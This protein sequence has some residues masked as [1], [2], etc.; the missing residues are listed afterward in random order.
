MERAMIQTVRSRVGRRLLLLT[1]AF[2]VAGSFGVAAA[3]H[4]CGSVNVDV[5]DA[6]VAGGSDSNRCGS[7]WTTCGTLTLTV[8]NEPVTKVRRY[9]SERQRDGEFGPA[10]ETNDCAKTFG[11]CAWEGSPKVVRS[12]DSTTITQTL[13][14]WTKKE[15]HGTWKRA[16]IY[17]YCD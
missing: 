1:L 8:L 14:N 17:A 4:M 10:V 5:V 15:E 3:E 16:T 12:G 9:V 2:S 7:A 13:N 6:P 11:A